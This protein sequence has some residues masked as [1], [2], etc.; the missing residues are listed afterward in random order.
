MYEMAKTQEQKKRLEKMSVSLTKVSDHVLGKIKTLNELLQKREDQRVQYDHY[1]DKIKKMDKD[2]LSTATDDDKQE[3][4]A[5][6]QC[7][8]D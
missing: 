6:N 3:R 4:F 5:R 8:F 7:K 1:R 2:G